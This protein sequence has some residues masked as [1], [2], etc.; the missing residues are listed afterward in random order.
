MESTKALTQ[1]VYN[2]AIDKLAAPLSKAVRGAYEVAGPL[3]QQ[4]KNA[5]HGVWLGHPLHPVFTDVPIGAWTTAL[6][7]DAAANGDPGMRR[8]ATFAIGVG[9]VGAVGAA[10][11]G[12]TDW[13]ETDGQSR[14]SGLIHGL[15]NVAAT[16]LFA[17]AYVL[18]RKDSHDG[19]RKC[20]WAGYA[21]AVGSAYLGGDLVYAQRLGVTHADAKLPEGFTPVMESAALPEN[22][23]ARGR[24]Q[25]ADVLVVRQHGSV[26]A[27]A[28][29]C[30]HRGGPLSEGTLKD[31]S[32]V[33]PW[34]GSEFALNDGSVL[35]GPATQNQPC[36][37][38]RERDGRIEVKALE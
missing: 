38:T 6:A 29:S 2:P 21:V 3:G 33:C 10:V 4:A 12:L 25:D 35:N 24:A 19:G 27:L 9:L 16:T 28:H 5:L 18:R 31:G 34:H 37:I 11:S 7:L 30:A 32:V 23:M 36:L 14:R 22:V 15:L 26:C 17:T 20:A 1:F 13:S 8:A